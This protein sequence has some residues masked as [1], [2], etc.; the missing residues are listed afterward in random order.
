MKITFLGTGTSTGNP[1]LLCSCAVCMSKDPKDQRLRSSILVEDTGV[2]ILIDCGPDFRQQALREGIK[3]ISAVFITHEHYDHVGGLDDLRPY[4]SYEEMPLFGDKRVLER[5]KIIMPYSFRENPY[6]GVPLFELHPIQ[7]DTF[8]LHHLKV[9]PILLHHHNLPVLGFR[10]GDFAYLT[11]FNRIDSDQLEKLKGCKT[12]VVDALRQQEH[13]SHNS[14]K[15]ALDV[16]DFVQPESSYLIHMSHDMGLFADIESNL[17]E[18]V[19]FSYDG[20]K[21]NL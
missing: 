6:P 18:H 7:L 1:M 8:K 21:L 12:L 11:D 9:T 3:H 13:I 4:C 5:L 2:S 16:I 14:L 19:H 10:I 15:Q 17:P 20:L